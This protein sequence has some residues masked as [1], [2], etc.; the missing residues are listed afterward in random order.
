[1]LIT[2]LLCGAKASDQPIDW[3]AALTPPILEGRFRAGEPSGI[4]IECRS[5]VAAAGRA[6]L[7]ATFDRHR[8]ATAVAVPVT[9]A[10]P[11]PIMVAIISVMIAIPITVA[12]TLTDADA[13][14]SECHIGLGKSN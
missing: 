5:S 4:D 12:A 14:G 11:Q 8:P 3:H 2:N 7:S 1:V 13:V 10:R 9:Q 6:R